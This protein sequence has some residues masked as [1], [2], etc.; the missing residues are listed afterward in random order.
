MSLLPRHSD[1]PFRNG[2]SR[3]LNLALSLSMLISSGLPGYAVG[4]PP[5]LNQEEDGQELQAKPAESLP[6]KT[7]ES[8]AKEEEPKQEE[9][10]A[11]KKKKEKKKKEKKRSKE[12]ET[13]LE[14]E[15]ESESE[16]EPE[17]SPTSETKEEPAPEPVKE[18]EPETN[19]KSESEAETEAQPESE[20][21]SETTSET[22]AEAE[23]VEQ[24]IKSDP[25]VKKPE[26]ISEADMLLLKNKLVEAE[27]AYRALLEDDEN[28]DAY[29]GL[30]VA[31]A[32]QK[33]PKKVIEAEGILRKCKDEF[34]E[35]PNMMA[36]AGLVAFEHSKTVASPSKRDLYLDAAENLCEKAIETNEDI[37][38]AQQTLGLVK[39]SRD[40][41]DNAIEPF[42]KCYQLAQDKVNGT[43]LAQAMLRVNPKSKKAAALVEEVL[44]LDPEYSPI[45]LQKAIVLTNSGKHEEAFTELHSISREDRESEWYKVQGDIYRKQGDGNSAVAS[46]KESIRRDPRNADPYKKLAEHY[47][48]R[49]DGELAISEMHSALE[50]LPNDIKLR[51][52]LAEL[53]LR[54][55]KLEVAEQEFRTILSV[56]QNDPSA[57]LGLARVFFRKARREGQYPQEWVQLKEKLQD[58]IEQRNVMGSVVKDAA[59]LQEKVDLA[60]AEKALTQKQFRDAGRYFRKVIDKHKE[61]AFQLLTLAEQAFNDGDLKTAELAYSYAREIPEV[62]P[63]AE[64]GISKI[65]SQRKEAERQVKLGDATEK[66]LPDVAEDHYKQSLIADPQGADAYYNLFFLYLKEKKDSIEP[67]IEYGENFLEA[68]EDSDNRR[69]QVEKLLFKLKE[70]LRKENSK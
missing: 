41:P 55:D 69:Q 8:T 70:R 4:S 23:P 18:A 53:A 22:E 28:G 24:P 54:L 51:Q 27:K 68:S 52:Q 49:G 62:A 47:M 1:T 7:E 33:N 67:T 5:Q 29:A 61:D 30:A 38:I 10:S 59:T 65:T 14:S 6:K 20:S 32:K 25:G 43:Y 64:Q 36:A 60:E 44:E 11:K 16:S 35:N 21:P 17:A 57:L 19:S 58:V 46:W 56:K 15:S 31:L 3:V 42:K 48:L 13:E 2:L 50:I 66:K 12:K 40:E 39:L 34:R 9:K 37:V 45:K 63:R 26:H